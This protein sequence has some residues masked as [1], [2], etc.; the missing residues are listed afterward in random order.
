MAGGF[1]RTCQ[2]GP[3][4]SSPVRR[5]PLTSSTLLQRAQSP[6]KPDCRACPSRQHSPGLTDLPQPSRGFLSMGSFQPPPACFAPRCS[7]SFGPQVLPERSSMPL[8]GDGALRFCPQG[9]ACQKG[10]WAAQ[11]SWAAR[12]PCNWTSSSL[13]TLACPFEA[14]C[15]GVGGDSACFGFAWLKEAGIGAAGVAQG[16]RASGRLR[17]G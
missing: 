8:A 16:L 5:R 13:P 14:L 2:I 15:Q 4:F 11:S 3:H 9:S 7:L 17:S 12:L 1:D 6:P 10:L